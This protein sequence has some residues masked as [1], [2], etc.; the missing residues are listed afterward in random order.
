MRSPLTLKILLVAALGTAST[1]AV[2]AGNV[3]TGRQRAQELGCQACHGPD[4]N[5][6]EPRIANVPRL[7]G[8]YAD[9]LVRALLEYQTG[10]RTNAI[11]SGM[12][13]NLSPEDRENIAAFY[14]SERGLGVLS[15]R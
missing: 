10:E 4:G 7:A 3:E 8:Q 1:T 5:G 15:S 11:M 9:Y 6:V 13:T 2:E 14:A 12:V